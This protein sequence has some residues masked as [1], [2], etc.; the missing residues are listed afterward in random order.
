MA[1]QRRLRVLPAALLLATSL[2]CAS[3]FMW[4]APDDGASEVASSEHLI[5]QVWINRIPKS[6][7][8]MI[9]IFV[10]AEKKKN[11]YGAVQ[12]ASR[13][14]FFSDT[15]LYTKQG[16]KLVLKFPQENKKVAVD[17]KTWKCNVKPFDLCLELKR[18]KHSLKMFSKK[19]WVVGSEAVSAELPQLADEVAIPGEEG[20]DDCVFGTPQWFLDGGS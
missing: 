2:V 4:P 18:G 3:Y 13:W 5:N 10:A 11:K 12:A 9:R 15:F 20:C 16:N 6:K 14:R 7:R 17:A 8:D 19:K 1:R